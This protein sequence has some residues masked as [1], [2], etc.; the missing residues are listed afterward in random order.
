MPSSETLY[1]RPIRRP[2]DEQTRAAIEAE[3]HR[4]RHQAPI[5]TEIHWHPS[6]PIFTLKATGV[7]IIGRFTEE[8]FIVDAELSLPIRLITTQGHR[9]QARR[10]IHEIAERLEL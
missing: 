7:A 3:F 2:F 10:M 8:K 4:R 5:P 1:E 9:D 6:E